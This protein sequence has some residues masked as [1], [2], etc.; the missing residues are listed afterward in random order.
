MEVGPYEAAGR[1]LTNFNRPWA[2]E[3]PERMRFV[4]LYYLGQEVGSICD[5]PDH[6]IRETCISCEEVVNNRDK[7]DLPTSLGLATA[8]VTAVGLTE[9]SAVSPLYALWAK[10]SFNEVRYNAQLI[11]AMVGREMDCGIIGNQTQAF[12]GW[13]SEFRNLPEQAHH[14]GLLSEIVEV[15]S[16]FITASQTNTLEDRLELSFEIAD[17]LHYLFNIAIINQISL[18]AAIR[19]VRLRDIRR[20]L[21]NRPTS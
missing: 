21:S 7:L 6:M 8:F 9:Y 20:F 5:G 19:D 11:N 10:T 4:H 3:T 17:L 1:I 12:E 15:R 14:D 18:P 16:A 2:W 13:L